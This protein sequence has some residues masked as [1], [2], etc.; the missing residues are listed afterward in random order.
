M[1]VGAAHII[2]QIWGT[3]PDN[4][5][6]LCNDGLVL[7]GDA[8]GCRIISTPEMQRE[9]YRAIGGGT[10]EDDLY[11]VGESGIM[12]RWDGDQWL[13]VESPTT[14]DLFGVAVDGPDVW[15]VSR[16]GE[17]WHVLEGACGKAGPAGE[18]GEGLI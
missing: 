12:T 8:H 5:F 14:D 1:L 18:L 11:L 15:T 16:L 13:D 17:L 4:V 2:R 9:P 6:Y 10:D 3:G 7:H